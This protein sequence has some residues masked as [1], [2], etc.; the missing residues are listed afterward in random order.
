MAK[1]MNPEL[2]VVR[3]ENED[4]IAR[5]YYRY[6]NT[7]KGWVYYGGKGNDEIDVANPTVN[8]GY[9]YGDTNNHTAQEAADADGG[10][11]WHYYYDPITNSYNRGGQ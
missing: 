9:G 10:N 6:D 2:E 4:V 1:M 5:S 8:F 7:K 11:N 3:F